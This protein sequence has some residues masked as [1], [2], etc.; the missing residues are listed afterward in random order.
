MNVQYR[1]YLFRVSSFLGV[2][3][4]FSA[5]FLVS[6]NRNSEAERNIT[7][8]K[9][10]QDNAIRFNTSE[11]GNQYAD[12]LPLKEIIK[13]AR[14]V[15]LGEATHGTREFFQMKHRLTEFLVRE[16]GFTIFAME[17]NWPE[18]ELVNEY[19]QSCQGN[20]EKLLAGMYFWT[21]QTQE[22]LDLLHWMC[23][24]NQLSNNESKVTFTGFDMQFSAV[25][26]ENV[27]EYI[28]KVDPSYRQE[29]RINYACPDG[30][31]VNNDYEYYS[32]A[33]KEAC[34]AKFGEVYQKLIDNQEEYIALSTPEEFQRA[35]HNA[36]LVLQTEDFSRGDEDLQAIDLRDEYMAANVKWLL[37]QAN[38]NDKIILWAHNGHIGMGLGEKFRTMGSHLRDIYGDEMIVVGFAFYEG[39]FTA[40][41]L[42]QNS[43]GRLSKHTAPPAIEESYEWY[44]HSAGIPRMIINLKDISNSTDNVGWLIEP[45][46]FRSI[47]SA[48]D[49][50]IPDSY[51]YTTSITQEFDIIIYFDETTPSILLSE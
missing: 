4:V 30:I 16:M 26:T 35:L 6:C 31:G 7:P 44:F 22:V 18:A 10:L 11:P 50:T 43:F 12:L 46:K 47:G 51:F 39:E 8:A 36:E 15:A 23:E 37:E 34:R 24:Y 49:E 14:I 5:G 2:I 38:E 27:I 28:R 32:I 25:A 42:H 13:D 41:K 1:R 21:W 19:V 20:P 40:I 3:F 9:W 29:A 45:H 48:Y 33:T 17:A